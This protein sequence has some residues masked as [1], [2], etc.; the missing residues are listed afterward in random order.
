MRAVSAPT[1]AG[2]LA[3]TISDTLPADNASSEIDPLASLIARGSSS[4]ISRRLLI[5][6]QAVDKRRRE[7]KLL[8]VPPPLSRRWSAP[9][10]QLRIL[11]R[12]EPTP[13]LKG[14]SVAAQSRAMRQLRLDQAPTCLH[15]AW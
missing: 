10:R 5:S 6:R 8:A 4:G 3:R 14:S 12:I 1:D 9:H 11:V 13:K 7:G 2:A 15:H